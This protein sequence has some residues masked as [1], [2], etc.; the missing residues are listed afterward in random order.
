MPKLVT[1]SGTPSYSTSHTVPVNGDAYV[2]NDV[3]SLAQRLLDNDAVVKAQADKLNQ[4]YYDL[5]FSLYGTI[6]P[7]VLALFAANVAFTL[8]SSSPGVARAGTAPAANTTLT[9]TKNGTQIGTVIFSASSTTGTVTISSATSVAVG[10]TIG[11]SGPVTSDT[12][13]ANVAITLN[14]SRVY[15]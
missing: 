15:A 8:P 13:L 5:A 14:G 1:A 6:L 7:G 4:V 2:A 3:E 9:I 11:I 12:A 10:D